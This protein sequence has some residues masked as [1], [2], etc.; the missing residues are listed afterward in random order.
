MSLD[1]FQICVLVAY[2]IGLSVGQVLFKLASN[3]VVSS[4]A[5]SG[6]LRSTLVMVSNGYFLTGTLL[7][8][9]LS[10]MWVWILTF[11]PL[12]RGYPFVALAFVSTGIFA[13]RLFGE[14]LSPRFFVGTAVLL[15][16]LVILG[17]E[18]G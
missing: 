8:A 7:Y 9:A 15:V 16:G 18:R 1:I 17:S 10:A 11:V 3:D 13:N 5:G 12:S 14:P 2:A 6:A 4:A